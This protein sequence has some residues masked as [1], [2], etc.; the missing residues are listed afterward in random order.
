MD[1]QFIILIL[2]AV[3]DLRAVIILN[4]ENINSFRAEL[5]EKLVLV[6]SDKISDELKKLEDIFRTKK[7]K[8]VVAVVSRQKN[9]IISELRVPDRDGIFFFKRNDK[10]EYTGVKQLDHIVEWIVRKQGASHIKKNSELSALVEKNGALL[11]G[12]FES[13]HSDEATIYNEVASETSLVDCCIVT[14]PNIMKE[15]KVEPGSVLLLK[16]YDQ[17]ETHFYQEFSKENLIDFI[18]YETLP[19]LIPFKI[20]YADKVMNSGRSTHFLLV[21]DSK[22]SVHEDRIAAVRSVGQLYRN[23]ILFVYVDIV[24]ES[25]PILDLLRVSE[26]MIP[27]MFLY[28]LETGFRYMQTGIISPLAVNKFI[29]DHKEGNLERI[30]MTESL[31]DEEKDEPVK[32]VVSLNFLES[33]VQ[34]D[35]TVFLMVYSPWSDK[36]KKLADVW[37][38]LGE[39]FFS[40]KNVTMAKMNGIKNEILTTKVEHYPSIVWVPRNE[41]DVILYRGKKTFASLKKFIEKKSLGKLKNEDDDD[42]D[43]EDEDEDVEEEEEGGAEEEVEQDDRETAREDRIPSQRATPGN[44]EEKAAK[45]EL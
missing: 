39:E 16:K 21:S 45:D 26:N 30:L 4:Q 22:D 37:N 29:M 36:C 10:F 34:N 13:I 40:N 9:D 38:K 17:P 14:D 18:K 41:D 23:E 28:E 5:A 3:P 32:T 6:S 25:Q 43:D 7:I 15:Y 12:F 11:V 27:C 19:Q 1:L 42:E 44:T 35:T 24:P 20:E 31:P 2:L 33:V 8:T